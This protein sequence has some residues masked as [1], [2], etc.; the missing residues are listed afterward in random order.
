MERFKTCATQERVEGS[1]AKKKAT[2]SD[3]GGVVAAKKSDFTHSKKRD[4][5]SDVLFE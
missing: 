1:L 2:K 4:F 3:V 5:A